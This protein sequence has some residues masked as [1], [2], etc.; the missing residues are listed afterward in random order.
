LKVSV[1]RSSGLPS[2]D[3][4]AIDAVEMQLL[5]PLPPE[6]RGSDVEIQFTFDYNVFGAS[7]Y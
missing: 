2:A 5:Q 6:F 1:S 3:K 4:A 7:R